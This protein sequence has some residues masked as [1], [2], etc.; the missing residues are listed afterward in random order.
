MF[1]AF[2]VDVYAMQGRI[3]APGIALKT[4]EELA[5]FNP[6]PSPGLPPKAQGSKRPDSRF[7]SSGARLLCQQNRNVVVLFVSGNDV[8]FAI[9]IQIAN[10]DARGVTAD[11][12]RRTGCD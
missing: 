5:E 1:A 2:A 7:T 10:R 11:L 6:K 4:A 8:S 9:T 3:V 12:K